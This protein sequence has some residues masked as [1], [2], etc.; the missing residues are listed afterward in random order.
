MGK[1]HRL[2]QQTGD[3]KA[4]PWNES[5]RR[6]EKGKLTRCIV[7]AYKVHEEDEQRREREG[8][9]PHG[10]P[11]P[12]PPM[13]L[14]Y[15]GRADGTA[16][17]DTRSIG[18]PVNETTAAN[19]AVGVE[20]LSVH[21]FKRIKA[22][23][24]WEL[25]RTFGPGGMHAHILEGLPEHERQPAAR[26]M[27]QLIHNRQIPRRLRELR[28]RVAVDATYI[29][30]K[31][32]TGDER[33]CQKCL[34]EG[35]MHTRRGQV[36][37]EETVQHRYHECPKE[38]W[39]KVLRW[40]ERRTGEEL[41]RVEKVTLLGVREHMGARSRACHQTSFSSLE[42]AF[43]TVHA[44]TL[45]TIRREAEQYTA[46]K[47]SRASAQLWIEVRRRVAE[48]ANARWAEIARRQARMEEEEVEAEE[49]KGR[50]LSETNFRRT[51]EAS[52]ILRHTGS[53]TMPWVLNWKAP[54][55]P[56][57]ATAAGGSRR[58]GRRHGSRK[59]KKL[60]RRLAI[61]VAAGDSK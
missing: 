37:I 47:G 60:L 53:K 44:A 23:R 33:Y 51:W 34:C 7:R 31:R 8:S 43:A 42:E 16:P 55:A 11:P 58:G 27:F 41:P 1:P 49:E 26:R 6:Y 32:R 30:P 54:T 40:W 45:E 19:T 61:R 5:I 29:G 10:H 28:Y 56:G 4:A 38:L 14:E 9:V 2:N 39:G 20:A 59:P 15:V 35:Q 52:G 46:T 57:A 25:P 18:I 21:E 13:R 48:M 50:P 3:V 12:K 24:E 36:M 17:L 22:A